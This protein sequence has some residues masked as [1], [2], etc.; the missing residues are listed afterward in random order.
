MKEFICILS[1][2]LFLITP[3]PGQNRD[4]KI[5]TVFHP[6][7]EN[8]GRQDSLRGSITPERKWWDLD[9]YHLQVDVNIRQKTLKGTNLIQ[10]RVLNASNRLQIDLQEPMKIVSIEQAGTPLTY[11]REGNV[12][13]IELLKEQVPG[14]LNSI[15]VEYEG[16]PRQAKR[17]PWDG[18]FS[19]E[20]DSNG[21]PFIATSCQGL[22]ASS[23]WPCKDHPFDEPDSM[24]MSFTVPS[25]LMA[26]SNG[27]LHGSEELKNG[28]KVWHWKVRN[29]INHYG[30]NL[31]IAKYV[32]F[33][34][35]YEGEKGPLDC[36]Y[37]VLKENLEEAKI[38]FAQVPMML[39]AFEYWFGPYPFY[40]DGFK[41]VQVPYL[42]MEHQSSVT[43]G[44]KFKNGYLGRDLS[45]TGQG[46]KFDF[47]IIHES[48]HEWFANSITYKDVADMW[49]HESF[50]QYAEGLYLEYHFGKEAGYEYLQGLRRNIR[51]DIPIIGLYDVNR[52]GSGDMY[53]KGAN[54]LHMIRQ[55]VDDDERWRSLLRGINNDYFHSTVSSE[56]IEGYMIH[57]TGL[58][59][60]A[61]FDQYLRTTE[62]PVFEYTVSKKGLRYR[63]NNCIDGFNMPVKIHTLTEEVWLQAK[64]HWQLI[65]MSE[66]PDHLEVSPAFYVQISE[67]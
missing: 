59:L 27:R 61:V 37:Y 12:Y 65:E 31:N 44:N 48:A 56:Q 32:Q 28:K 24:D 66:L 49:I 4:V 67:L 54:M 53:A 22:G 45:G 9:Y 43:Y 47:I 46:L 5:A 13:F 55:L 33:E 42:G 19:W 36:S 50:G 57:Y 26:V 38:Q 25:D 20:K 15:L 58:D 18:G 29:P 6:E 23:W 64:D 30:V 35:L 16:K 14:Q 3:V 17:A 21:N 63:W 11:T 62:I 51:N 41:L 39:E 52:E 10:Y 40:E 1:L 7:I 34:E 2:V 8:I 60:K